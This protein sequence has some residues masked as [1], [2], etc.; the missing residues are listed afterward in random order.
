[1]RLGNLRGPVPD[2]V[3][4]PLLGAPSVTDDT[5]A[6]T[7]PEVNRWHRDKNPDVQTPLRAN[8]GRLITLQSHPPAIL[9]HSSHLVL[10]G[11]RKC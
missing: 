6:K 5:L 3:I 9:K 8:R 7:L 1:M 11:A 4:S 2:L 10:R